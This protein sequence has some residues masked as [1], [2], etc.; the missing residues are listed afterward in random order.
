MAD[1]WVEAKPLPEGTAARLAQLFQALSDA[2]RVRI[3]SVLLDTELCVG[4]IADSLEMSQS[5]ISH[6]LR[7]LREL[8]LVRTRREGKQIFYTLDDDHVADLFQTG[9]DHAVHG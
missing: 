3:V 2:T 9:L 6:Q 4:D 5:A 1:D 8:R 7:T